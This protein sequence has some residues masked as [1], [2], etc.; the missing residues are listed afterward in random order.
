MRDTRLTSTSE[1]SG[2]GV[3][4]RANVQTHRG[5]ST[6]ALTIGDSGR[7]DERLRRAGNQDDRNAR[8]EKEQVRRQIRHRFGA[9]A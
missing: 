3:K 8:P 5:E 6:S 4:R 1:P 2:G 9:R 7:D